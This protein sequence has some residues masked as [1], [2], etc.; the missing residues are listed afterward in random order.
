M[1]GGQAKVAI[2]SARLLADDGLDVTFFAACGPVSSALDHPRIRTV[3]LN[4]RTILDDPSR[5]R[6]MVR[7]V[8]NAAA[9]AALRNEAHSLDPGTTVLHCHGY[10]KALSPA[11][12]PVLAGGPLRSVFTMHE[13]FLAC[14]NGGFYDYRRGAICRRT[15]LG[16]GCLTTN[17]DSR[18]AAHKAWRVVRGLA[19]RGP[20]RLPRGLTDVICIS[21]TQRR[22]MAPY[23]PDRARLHQVSNPVAA[24]GPG[25]DF[26]ANRTLVFVGRLS[27]EKAPVQLAEAAR[28][29]GRPVTFVGEGPEAAAIRRANPRAEITGWLHPDDVQAHLAG[30]AALVFPS[31]WYECQPLAPIE[32]LL[33]GVPVICGNWNAAAEV[34]RDGEN[35]IVYDRAGVAGL[36]GAIERLPEIAPFNSTELAAKVSPAAHLA[37]LREVYGSMLSD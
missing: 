29:A 17:C 8:W 22:A 23:L 12:G 9:A 6:A 30:A 7:G 1:T 28:A 5:L 37:R 4:Q 32:A 3:C 21:E 10:A 26:S 25:V 15:P 33:R 27:P 13:Y 20:G 11:I 14:P 36:T 31:L 18:R 19:A 16:A 35:G 24:L 2:D 34:V